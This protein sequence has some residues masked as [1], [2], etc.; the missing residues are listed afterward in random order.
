MNFL[1]RPLHNLLKKLEFELILSRQ[2]TWLYVIHL[3]QLYGSH[4]QD[5][6]Y[7]WLAVCLTY[8]FVVTFLSMNQTVTSKKLIHVSETIVS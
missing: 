5:C 2:R 1:S 3:M 6:R 7:W 4:E 8:K